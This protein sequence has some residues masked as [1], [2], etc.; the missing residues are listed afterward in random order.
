MKKAI[1]LLYFVFV[2][3]SLVFSQQSISIT[4]LGSGDPVLFL[5][6]FATPGEVWVKT[7]TQ[8]PD[9]QSLLVTYAGFGDVPPMDFPWYEKIKIDLI[10][11]ISNQNLKNLTLVGHSM[12]GNLAI[13]I[14]AAFPDRV[15]KVVVV[16][17]LACMREVMMPGVPAE[18]LGYAS[19]YNDQL[20]AMDES[21]QS[22]YLDQ[23]IQNMITYPDDQKI[24]KSWMFKADRKTFVYGYVDLLKLDSR[25]LLPEVKADVLI[26]VAG[27][28]F[29]AGALDTMKNQY[30][31]LEKK[32]FMLAS[33]SRHYIMLD[34]QEWFNDQLK[35]FISK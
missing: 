20:L 23:M 13:D 26:M 8:L 35:S 10:Q 3:P 1:F 34:Q 24:V 33:E 25:P 18:A 2:L 19:P 16:D 12:G 14:A 31:G 29:G 7:S 9:Y 28:P 27:K 15:Q 4:S 6:G 30:T 21:A 5:P 11:Y 32:E 17:A 22:T